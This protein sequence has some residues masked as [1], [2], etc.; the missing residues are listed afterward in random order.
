MAESPGECIARCHGRGQQYVHSQT[1]ECACSPCPEG[2]RLDARLNY[3]RYGTP[4]DVCRE[5]CSGTCGVD[6]ACAPC[7]AGQIQY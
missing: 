7:P 2:T 6:G 3:C 4:I 1:S 5:E